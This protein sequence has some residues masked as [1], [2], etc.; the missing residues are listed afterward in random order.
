[1]NWKTI[2]E[3]GLP[4]TFPTGTGEAKSK[5]CLVKGNWLGSDYKVVA[6]YFSDIPAGWFD[7]DGNELNG[8]IISYSEV[9]DTELSTF[10]EEMR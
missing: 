1:M 6:W 4:E 5:L 7:R 10:L 8:E 3:H 2:K 9:N